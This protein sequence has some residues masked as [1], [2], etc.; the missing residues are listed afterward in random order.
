MASDH[1]A[2]FHCQ[3][4][5]IEGMR[6]FWDGVLQRIKTHVED[7]GLRGEADVNAPKSSEYVEDSD[8]TRRRLMHF[9]QK[10]NR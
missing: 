7:E 1:F 3:F 6:E 2:P 8:E 4:F 10:E 9:D 5:E